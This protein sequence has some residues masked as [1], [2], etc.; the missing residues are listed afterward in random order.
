MNCVDGTRH[1]APGFGAPPCAFFARARARF[2]GAP[3]SFAR[4]D[5][6]RVRACTPG[7]RVYV[8]VCV[9]MRGYTWRVRAVITCA[10]AVNTGV[11]SVRVVVVHEIKHLTSASR[12]RCHGGRRENNTHGDSTHANDQF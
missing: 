8:R 6:V 3:E 5:R 4:L 10:C 7:A 9:R 2:I 11:Q 1:P 12:L